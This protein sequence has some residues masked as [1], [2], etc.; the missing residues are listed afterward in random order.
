MSVVV[1]KGSPVTGPNAEKKAE[2]ITSRSRNWRSSP[3]CE[4]TEVSS[5][6]PRS[7]SSVNA[8]SRNSPSWKR[9]S[10]ESSS[11]SP[12]AESM[13]GKSSSSISESIASTSRS[14]RSPGDELRSARTE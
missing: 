9:G 13:F 3:V 14:T 10:L 2:A 7:T 8:Y 11:R 1:S 5:A 6:N 12:S 4:V